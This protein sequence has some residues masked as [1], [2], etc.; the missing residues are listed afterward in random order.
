MYERARETNPH[1]SF[2]TEEEKEKEGEE[3][4]CGGE[5]SDTTFKGWERNFSSFEGSREIPARPSGEGM[6]K[7]GK[8]LGNEKR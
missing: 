3:K 7:E 8:A 4:V 1:S 2:T 6:F 5:G